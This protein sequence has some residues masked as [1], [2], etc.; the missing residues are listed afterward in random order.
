TW[1]AGDLR[2]PPPLRRVAAM[3][4]AHADPVSGLSVNRMAKVVVT[5]ETRE[6]FVCERRIVPA[7]RGTCRN[8]HHRPQP[9][10]ASA[11]PPFEFAKLRSEML[12]RPGSQVTVRANAKIHMIRSSPFDWTFARPSHRGG[13][14]F[15]SPVVQKCFSKGED[16]RHRRQ[17]DRL[18]PLVAN[19]LCGMTLCRTVT[20]TEVNDYR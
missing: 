20:K 15:D 19:L 1:M 3:L 8:E 2:D 10:P 6:V 11:E 14:T 12:R 16:I 13:S 17:A 7:N 9:G 4:T 18:S 5:S